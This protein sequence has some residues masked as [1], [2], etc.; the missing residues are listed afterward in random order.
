MK[1]KAQSQI[2]SAILLIL[3]AVSAASIIATFATKFVKDQLETSDCF[4]VVD[5]LEISNHPRYTCYDQ[6]TNNMLVQIHLLNADIDGFIIEVGG[7]ATTT[8]T[9]KENTK[10]TGVTMYNGSTTLK[11]PGKNEERTYKINSQKPEI[12]TLYPIINNKP[13][14][15]SDSITEPIN[16]Y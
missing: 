6:T 13:C 10:L 8:Y 9:I 7:A 14:E 11:L 5:K 4:D 1:T 15:A 12:I 16:C 2:I 3:I